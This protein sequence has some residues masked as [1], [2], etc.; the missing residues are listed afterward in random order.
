MIRYLSI[1]NFA[2][3]ENTEIEFNDG[4]NIITGETG[5]GKSIVIEAVSLAL[6]SR[7]DTTF[8]RSGADKAVIQMI[9]EHKGSEYVITR[10]ISSSG[11]N[12]CRINDE[13]VTLGHLSMV[14]KKLADIHGQYDHQSLLNPEY[15]IKLLDLYHKDKI[16]PAKET[17]KKLYE[18]Y[19][20]LKMQLRNITLKSEKNKREQDFMQFEL[21]ELKDASLRPGED[22]ELEEKI[23]LLQNSEKIYENLAGAYQMSSEDEYS[24]ISA[25][26]KI[27]DMVTE[28]APYSSELE[29]LSERLNELYYDFEDICSSIRDSRDNAVFSPEELDAYI[30]RIETINRLK[31]KHGKSIVQLLSYQEELEKTLSELENSDEIQEELKKQLSK[32]ENA[33][34][35]S[36]KKLSA[37]R[38]QAAEELEKEITQEL[39]Q[40]NFNDAE[41]S[42]SFTEADTFSPEGTDIAEFMISTNRGEPLKPLSRIASGGEMSRIML[43][44]KKIVG[45]YDEIPTM[46]FDEIDSGISGITASIVGKKLREI[47]ENHQIICITHLPQIAAF[48]EHNYKIQKSSDDKMTYTTVSALSENEK[49]NEIARLLGGANI[50][51]TTLKSAKELIDASV[52]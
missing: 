22:E 24:V 11:K 47:S 17:V 19:S 23:S 9:A 20:M 29:E 48:G 51:D 35:A 7:A 15:H 50:T 16:L 4:L 1:K 32:C 38:K 49:T 36:C 10:Q 12:I 30:S 41:F 25:L 14:C 18:N 2:T 13:V 8:I 37:A 33:L 31:N 44:F 21:D 27:S 6:G 40:L 43:A 39:K 3:I 52:K 42:I 45:D 46:I 26:K 28:T 34:T 5:A